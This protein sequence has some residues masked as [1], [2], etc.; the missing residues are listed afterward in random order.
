MA[1]YKE[2]T[3]TAVDFDAS[4]SPPVSLE[5]T[6]RPPKVTPP[7]KKNEDEQQE[8]EDEQQQANEVLTAAPASPTPVEPSNSA[9]Q[10]MAL[11]PPVASLL[12]AAPA[13]GTRRMRSCRWTKPPRL[14][15][16]R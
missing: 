3:E 6:A 13:E 14:P 16:R 2:T 9:A 11:S 1:F 4:L 12:P 7:D 15:P 10:T 5:D 8:E